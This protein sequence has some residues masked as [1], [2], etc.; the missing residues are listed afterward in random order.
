[1]GTLALAD[2]LRYEHNW[3]SRALKNLGDKDL[4]EAWHTHRC[5]KRSNL[6]L[7]RVLVAWHVVDGDVKVQH[8]F[9]VV[10]CGLSF[11]EG[12]WV[13]LQDE[14]QHRYVIGTVPCRLGG[15]NVF[16]WLPRFNDVRFTPTEWDNANSPPML[17]IAMVYRQ[18]HDLKDGPVE[19]V[20][21]LSDL[22]DFK[23]QAPKYR[24][25]RF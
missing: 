24:D 5:V 8:V 25:A 20:D 9:K 19:G 6:F 3:A 15:L 21:Y 17:R 16:P 22:N 2:K 23:R 11:T 4:S 13:V 10:G 14:A 7:N 18:G 1:M 12:P